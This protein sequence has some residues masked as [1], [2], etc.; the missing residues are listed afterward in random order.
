VPPPP[1]PLPSPRINN[2]TSMAP[3]QVQLAAYANVTLS[4]SLSDLPADTA[5]NEGLL[6]ASLTA[7]A[8]E[9]AGGYDPAYISVTYSPPDYGV[10]TAQFQAASTQK[11]VQKDQETLVLPNGNSSSTTSSTSSSSSG[12]RLRQSGGSV[13]GS[14]RGSRRVWVSYTRMAPINATT[15]QRRIAASCG[16]EA[17]TG[18]LDLTGG[19]CAVSLSDQLRDRGM[20]LSET[21]AVGLVNNEPPMVSVMGLSSSGG[22]GGGVE[23]ARGGGVR[24]SW[25][26]QPSFVPRDLALR[27]LLQTGHH[28]ICYCMGLSMFLVLLL[29]PAGVADHSAGCGCD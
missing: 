29:L 15:L 19:P 4:L 18:G 9:W 7:A 25:L 3:G 12:R 6:T 21:G 23:E 1:P 13:V 8:S 10:K 27:S 2:F 16:V 5:F 26:L 24:T 22:R 20:P 14:S 17:L 11:V 28:N